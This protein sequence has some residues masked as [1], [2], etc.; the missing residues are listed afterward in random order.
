[1]GEFPIAG[2]CFNGM[3]DGVAE[4]QEG[5]PSL[6]LEFILAD[7]LGLDGGIPC[8]EGA[9]I[10]G[11]D[12]GQ[13]IEHGLVG[14]HGV[15]DD[16]SQSFLEDL[17]RQGR[18]RERI[19][20]HKTRLVKGA[21]QVLTKRAINPRLSTDRAVDLGNDRRWQLN[22]GDAAVVDRGDKS[23]QITH[24]ASAE[25]KDGTLAIQS[26]M[27][28]PITEIGGKSHRFGGFTC[29]DSQ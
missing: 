8:D 6:G 16:F 22:H 9:E 14:D 7:D 3:P 5:T 18:E 21:Y 27:D 11:A 24:N 26:E 29:G 1:M 10:R 17:L 28:H 12:R 13:K 20:E 15:L 19:G 25:C 23:S 4:I 2:D